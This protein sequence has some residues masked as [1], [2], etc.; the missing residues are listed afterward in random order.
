MANDKMKKSNL[1][2]KLVK[3]LLS[4]DVQV[5]MSVAKALDEFI[6]VDVN[7]QIS[8]AEKEMGKALKMK[9]K[10]YTGMSVIGNPAATHNVLI[11]NRIIEEQNQAID[12]YLENA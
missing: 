2:E 5:T 10:G 9:K 11:Y 7:Q 12:N 1:R 8:L 4:E 6:D 3:T